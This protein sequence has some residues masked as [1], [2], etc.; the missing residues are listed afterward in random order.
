MDG[1]PWLVLGAWASIAALWSRLVFQKFKNG[2]G[3]TLGRH[4]LIDEARSWRATLI[5][6]GNNLLNVSGGALVL[7]FVATLFGALDLF[8]LLAA[9]GNTAV[10]IL[11][12][13][14]LLRRAATA[15]G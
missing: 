10:L 4:A 15:G 3:A 13:G 9:L 8:L 1:A 5:R 11:T 2:F 14:R 12:F 6:A 7:L